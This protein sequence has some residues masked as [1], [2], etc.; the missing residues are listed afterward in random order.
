M[1]AIN[2]IDADPAFVPRMAELCD[3]ASEPSVT[4]TCFEEVGRYAPYR[5]NETTPE[6]AMLCSTL[7][8]AHRNGACIAYK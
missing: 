3:A 1:A 6:F 2:M 8:A 5:F 7:P 4:N